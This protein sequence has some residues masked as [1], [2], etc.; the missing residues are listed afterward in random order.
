MDYTHPDISIQ[1]RSYSS[2]NVLVGL[3]KVLT[4]DPGLTIQLFLLIPLVA[5]GV[6]LQLNGLQWTLTLIVTL[7]FIA[8]GI[9]RRAALLQISHDSS[10]SSFHASRIRCMGTA[11]VAITGGISLLTYLLVF[12]PKIIALMQVL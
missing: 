6:V 5:G 10:L 7:L 2:P 8:A 11:I 3:R 1:A 12:V 4:S 9:F